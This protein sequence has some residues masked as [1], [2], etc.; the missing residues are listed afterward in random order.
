M[1]E[2]E[3]LMRKIRAVDFAI[4]EVHIFLDTHPTDTD[5]LALNDKYGKRRDV[6]VTEY[7]QKYGPLDMSRVTSSTRWQWISD[8]WPWEYTKEV[9]NDVGL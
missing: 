5:A 1:S 9:P 2:Q 3:M 6:L 7:E 4:W 8:P